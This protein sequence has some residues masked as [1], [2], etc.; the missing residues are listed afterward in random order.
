MSNQ[1]YP[2]SWPIGWP[3]TRVPRRSR[4]GSWNK[5]PSVASSVDELL[6]ELDRMGATHVVISTNLALRLDG[7]PRSNQSKPTDTGAAVY[8][9]RK[10]ADHVLPCDT[11]DEVGCNI[12]ALART[13]NA[14]RQMERDGCTQIVG[15]AF[16][17]FRALPPNTEA[18]ARDWQT[19]LGYVAG[20]DYEQV[21]TKYRALVKR[22]HPDNAATG[23]AAEFR[24][25]QAAWDEY[26]RLCC[27]G[28]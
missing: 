10:G 23:D 19:V 21:R 15:Q 7:L 12:Y 27:N 5:K 9:K 24:R 28:G 14:L 16:T 25:V 20:D 22:Y 13:V 6:L 17:G 4:F 26:D 1:A 3:R 11:F 2:L 18:A 8:F